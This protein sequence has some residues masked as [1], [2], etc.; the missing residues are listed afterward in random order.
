MSK[1]SET[2]IVKKVAAQAAE[3][4]SRRTISALQKRTETTSGDDSG[5]K[6]VWDEV[7]VQVQYERS[8]Y[9]DAYDETVRTFVAAHSR[10]YPN[11][12]AK[13]F[14]FRLIKASIGTVKTRRTVN[15]TLSLLMT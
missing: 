15:N 3:R 6:T 14:G 1:L 9:W 11:T 13:P 10:S 4:V 7:C 5:F 2:G 12:N 8:F